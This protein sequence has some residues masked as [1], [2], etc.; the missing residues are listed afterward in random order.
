MAQLLHAK[1]KARIFYTSH[2][3]FDTKSL[4]RIQSKKFIYLALSLVG[5]NK[6]HASSISSSHSTSKDIN[7]N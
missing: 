3:I 4:A 6:F 7:V 1:Q 5:P 2:V